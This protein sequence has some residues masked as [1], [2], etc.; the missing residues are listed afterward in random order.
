MTM[1]NDFNLLNEDQKTECCVALMTSL[2]MTI[3]VYV[4]SNEI[5][6]LPITAVLESLMMLAAAGLENSTQEEKQEYISNA[7]T[8]LRKI[9]GTELT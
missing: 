4:H 8:F 3:Q 5:D 9:T 7:V 2:Q 6:N 1:T